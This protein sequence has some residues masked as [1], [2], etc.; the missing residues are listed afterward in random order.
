MGREPLSDSIEL[1]AGVGF[2]LWISFNKQANYFSH[3]L[4]E[5]FRPL[6]TIALTPAFSHRRMSLKTGVGAF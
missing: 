3:P 5:A 2:G 4:M 1:L 6:P